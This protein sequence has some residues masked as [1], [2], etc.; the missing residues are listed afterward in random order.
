MDTADDAPSCHQKARTG[1]A[2]GQAR[3]LDMWVTGDHLLS[4]ACSKCSCGSSSSAAISL[5]NPKLA[6]QL[7]RTI[8][9]GWHMLTCGLQCVPGVAVEAVAMQ[10]TNASGHN[11]LGPWL[12]C[13]KC[14]LLVCSMLQV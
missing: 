3:S 13:H 9:L 7:H 8:V 5:D 4:A 2:V 11:C 1:G 10:L 6:P 14:L 12:L